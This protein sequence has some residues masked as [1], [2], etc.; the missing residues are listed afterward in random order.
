MRYLFPILILMLS[1]SFI[2]WIGCGGGDASA[3]AEAT[4]DAGDPGQPAPPPPGPKQGNKPQPGPT[5]GGGQPV[6]SN[7]GGNQPAPSNPRPVHQDNDLAPRP[8]DQPEP[9]EL[10]PAPEQLIEVLN[11][12]PDQTQQIRTILQETGAEINNVVQQIQT[13]VDQMGQHIQEGALNRDNVP[14]PV[15]RLVALQKQRMVLH[16]V[17]LKRIFSV[18]EPPQRE[19]YV[20]L[21][22]TRRYLHHLFPAPELHHREARTQ[23]QGDLPSFRAIADHFNFTPQQR[24]QVVQ[25]NQRHQEAMQDI[26]PRVHNLINTVIE[27]AHASNFQKERPE[28]E[29]MAERFGELATQ[30][31]VANLRRVV[32]VFNILTPEQKQGFVQNNL[33]KRYA[34][35]YFPAHARPQ[36]AR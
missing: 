11:L 20:E 8:A 18:L 4:V 32:A 17:R 2:T 27:E 23:R 24:E 13:M 34:K 9:P 6:A 33:G 16:L 5:G 12:S 26:L 31:L 21:K 19:K 14:E 22:L 30:V 25:I 28:L 36:A 35:F 1:I 15:Q 3:E 29:G 7:G 10:P